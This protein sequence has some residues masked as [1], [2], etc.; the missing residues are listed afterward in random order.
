LPNVTPHAL[1]ER[2][3]AEHELLV[4]GLTPEE[5]TFVF[6]VLGGMTQT[7]AYLKC[8]PNVKRT[9]AAVQ[10]CWWLT[11]PKIRDAR[12]E[13]LTLV[14][15]EAMQILRAAAGDAASVLVEEL[16][17]ADR[18][19]AALAILDRIGAGPRMGLDVSQSRVNGLDEFLEAAR[20]SEGQN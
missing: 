9:T 13:L 2:A 19:A 17:G 1:R 14:G 20:A 5:Q 16:K 10:G 7:D 12:E 8:H 3:E 18:K 6:D 15:R 11:R 4:W